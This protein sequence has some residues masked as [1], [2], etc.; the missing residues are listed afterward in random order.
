[1]K[2]FNILFA[3]M[4]VVSTLFAQVPSQFSYQALVRGADG[5]VVANGNVGLRLTLLQGSDS[6]PAVWTSTQTVTTNANGVLSAVVGG[7]GTS[8]GSVDWS[9]GPYYLR[10]EV[11]PTGGSNYELVTVQQLLSVPYALRAATVESH[12][13]PD[14]TDEMDAVN[15]R[16]LNAALQSMRQQIDSIIAVYGGG[17]TAPGD[18]VLVDTVWND[19]IPVDSSGVDTIWVDT[20]SGGEWV[21]LGLPSGLLWASHNVGATGP[22]DYGNYY[23]WGETAT[24]TTYNWRTYTYGNDFLIKYC[25]YSTFGLNGFTDTLTILQP[26]DDAA[27]SNMGNGARTPTKAEWQELLNNTTSTWTSRNGVNGRLFTASNGNS[28]FLPAAGYRLDGGLSYAGSCGRYWSSS[29]NAGY[30]KYAWNFYFDSGGQ[31]MDSCSRTSGFPVRAVRR[32]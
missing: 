27:T 2:R 29:L 30:S 28:I 7:E 10:S 24:K 26:G 1:M 14:P 19:T 23:A 18:T 8:L 11:D 31:Y 21:D 3:L 6:G 15:L 20:V 9:Q 4:L 12:T 17:S 13:V 25:N 22:E 32:N 16:T 5:Q